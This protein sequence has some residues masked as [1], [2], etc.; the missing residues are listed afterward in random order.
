MGQIESII[1][2]VLSVEHETI[3][4]KLGLTTK[5]PAKI[6]QNLL[7]KIVGLI[8]DL[9]RQT[10]ERSH[11]ILTTLSAILW[12]YRETSWDGLK[13]FLILALSRSGLGPSSIMVD[14]RYEDGQYSAMESFI[15]QM[16]VS[17]HQFKYEVLICEKSFL[18]TSFQKRVWEKCEA[19]TLV[20]ISAP[21]SAGKSFIIL[22]KAIDLLIKQDGCVVYIVPTLSLVSQVYSDFTRLLKKFNL[23]RYKILT[24]CNITPT[25]RSNS[26]F[27]LTQERAINAFTQE[28]CPFENVRLLVVDE[29]QN[30]E[31]VADDNEQRS[32]VLYDTLI[33]FRHN[34]NID[35]TI[36][37]G[38]R[39]ENLKSLGL[40]LFGDT[41]IAEE[42]TTKDS[43]VVSITYAINKYNNRYFFNQYTE[44][45]PSHKS[46]LIETPDFIQGYG[47]AQYTDEYTGYLSTIIERLGRNN[48]NV[49][50]SPTKDQA[51]NIASTLAAKISTQSNSLQQSL[52][53]YIKSTVRDNYGLANLILK[54]TAYHHGSLP[55]HIRFVIEEAIK[56][57]LVTNIVCTTTLMQG[58]NLPAQNV[59][60]RNPDLAIKKP[61]NGTKPKLTNYE[62]ANLRGRAGRLLKDFI[63]RTYVLDGNAFE[64]D[65]DSDKLFPETEKEL[66]SGYGNKYREN[67]NDINEVLLENI[68]PTTS[69]DN[70]FLVTYIRQAILRYGD[71]SIERLKSVGIELSRTE[72][73]SISSSLR[74]LS[75]NRQIC[76]N[77]RYW[78][79]FD[80]NEIFIRQDTFDLPRSTNETGIESKLNS[81]LTQMKE[82]YPIYYSRYWK[83]ADRANQSVCIST[84][85]WLKEKLLS[86]ILSSNYYDDPTNIEKRIKILQSSVSYGMPMLFKPLYDIKIPDSTFPRFIELGAYN[87]ITRRL[88]ELNIPRETAITLYRNH[89]NGFNQADFNDFQLRNKIREVYQT[90]PYW[91]KV[92]LQDMV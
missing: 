37:S 85:E 42:E 5:E 53:N 92:Q 39:V 28:P 54:G 57:K 48:V 47:K 21:T 15:N 13:D 46:I 30:I 75:V 77:N 83:V 61:K 3:A 78:D 12:T 45:S 24:N 62:I 59:I 31:R 69:G 89:F 44:I 63:G 58:V 64:C 26:I 65:P 8:D 91:I 35:L 55:M 20:G 76:I 40:E 17:I 67:K 18:L 87:P 56:Q 10:D 71:L 66:H 73:N 82:S 7:Y 29:I 88:I 6:E 32:K 86:E 90:L 36:I 81:L 2:L 80:I 51:E 74:T 52:S 60:I 19:N 33:E 4:H 27:I 70:A 79:P 23:S 34:S 68:A 38:P 1:D 49:I 9:S 43:P 25:E 14:D 41:N 84:K 72:Y 50:F 16:A 11:R 22:L